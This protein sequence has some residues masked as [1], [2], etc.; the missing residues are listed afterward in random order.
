MKYNILHGFMLLLLTA[1]SA[2]ATVIDTTDSENV[3]YID[4]FTLATTVGGTLVG[5]TPAYQ[6]DDSVFLFEEKQN[7]TLSNDLMVDQLISASS[8][9]L[10]TGSSHDSV[11]LAGNI[12]NSYL[13]NFDAITASSTGTSWTREIL[14]SF[15]FPSDI[16]AIIW[17][18]QILN[19]STDTEYD[20]LGASD[21]V[22]SD[23]GYDFGIGRGLEP[24]TASTSTATKDDFTISADYRTIDFS[25]KG[26]PEFADHLRVITR[27][28]DV[29][30]PTTLLLFG[31]ALALFGFRRL[32]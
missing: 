23:I 15:T 17:T 9:T 24:P 8:L 31:S 7:L 6:S 14:G 2:F 12:I 13:L 10:D 32:S 5:N 26:I 21:G 18:G 25:F 19:P 3:T 28:V 20:L 30:E 29:P 16:I 4:S 11:L 22:L 27:T 1:P